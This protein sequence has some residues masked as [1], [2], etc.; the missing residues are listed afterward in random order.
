MFN[1]TPYFSE[2]NGFVPIGTF[3][4]KNNTPYVEILLPQTDYPI[5]ELPSSDLDDTPGTISDDEII[6][7]GLNGEFEIQVTQLTETDGTYS[8]EGTAYIDWLKARIAV[9]FRE[10]TVNADKRLLT[11]KIIAK[12]T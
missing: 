8:G 12:K 5:M 6:H 7:A 10:I 1:D 4:I 2:N 11:G 3:K 9:K